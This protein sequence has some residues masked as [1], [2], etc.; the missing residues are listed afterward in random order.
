MP[1][2]RDG[3]KFRP[4]AHKLI[5]RKMKGWKENKIGALSQ[6]NLQTPDLK[7][8][9]KLRWVPAKVVHDSEII[10]LDRSLNSVMTVIPHD[11]GS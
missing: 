7:N 9:S 8:P 11:P 3:P 10:H 1:P 5:T 6:I 2:V 4:I